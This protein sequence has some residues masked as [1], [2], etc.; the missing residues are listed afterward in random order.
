MKI[1]IG[2]TSTPHISDTQGMFHIVI[3]EN[4]LGEWFWT[5]SGFL[6]LKPIVSW[7]VNPESNLDVQ[8]PCLH[9]NTSSI[10]SHLDKPL[11][12][13]QPTEKQVSD[14]FESHS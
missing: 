11:V 8:E 4:A 7:I 1:L 2:N 10:I 3:L 14:S 12:R 6:S 5:S 9:T 13:Q